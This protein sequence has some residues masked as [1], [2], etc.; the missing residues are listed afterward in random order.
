MHNAIVS[1]HF[2]II[3]AFTISLHKARLRADVS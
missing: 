3:D 1:M 2:I